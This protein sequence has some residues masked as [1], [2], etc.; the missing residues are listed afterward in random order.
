M[1]LCLSYN[2]Q[3]NQVFTWFSMIFV[4]THTHTHIAREYNCNIP[5]Y[6]MPQYCFT[7]VLRFFY[8]NK[9]TINL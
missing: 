1:N 6:Q 9:I 4:H 5:Y 2:S 3:L 8:E 7:A